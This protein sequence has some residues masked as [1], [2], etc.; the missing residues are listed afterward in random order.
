[1]PLIVTGDLAS[2]CGSEISIQAVAVSESGDAFLSELGFKILL[3]TQPEPPDNKNAESYLYAF[4]VDKYWE[5]RNDTVWPA[6]T[7]EAK[8]GALRIATARLNAGYEWN[9]SIT[10]YDQALAFPRANICDVEGRAQSHLKIPKAIKHALAE[11]AYEQATAGL[12]VAIRPVDQ[13]AAGANVKKEAI[14]DGLSVEYFDP[15]DLNKAIRSQAQPVFPWI[16]KMLR[17]AGLID[18]GSGNAFTTF[19]RI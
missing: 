12:D 6:L 19:D 14:D 1:M 5:N 11:L 10:C 17:Y 2:A 3:E 4:E 9:G 15:K 8:E 18:G 7:Q 13:T 16:D